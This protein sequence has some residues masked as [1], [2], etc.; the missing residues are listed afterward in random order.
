MAVIGGLHLLL[1]TAAHSTHFL[2]FVYRTKLYVRFRMKNNEMNKLFNV[3][4]T[5]SGRLPILM[6]NLFYLQNRSGQTGIKYGLKKKQT[7]CQTQRMFISKALQDSISVY[8]RG[9][10]RNIYIFHMHLTDS[11]VLLLV[12]FNYRLYIQRIAARRLFSLR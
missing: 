11:D 1:Q 12:T 6:W 8:M 4:L 9:T 5:M 3:W 7:G 10:C 2:V